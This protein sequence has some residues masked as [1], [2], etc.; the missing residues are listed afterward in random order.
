M[1]AHLRVLLLAVFSAFMSLNIW[2]QATSQIQGTVQDASGAAVPGATVK[3]TQTDT[4]FTRTVTSSAE[5]LY[6]LSNLPIGPYTLE[7]TKDGFSRYVQTGIVLQVNVS[8]T[9]DIPLR[10]GAVTEQVN[11]EANATLVETQ[12]TGVGSVIENQ[13]ILELPLNG[14]NATDLIQ[15]AGGA[16]PQGTSSSR[17]MQGGQAIAVAGGQ[18]Y[19]IAYF[20][21]GTT[22]NNPYDNLNLPFP[23]PDSLQE[24]KVETGATTAVNGGH[25]GA[26]VNAVT[27]SGTNSFH[28]SA[29]EFLRNAAVNGRDPFSAVRDTLKRNQYGG[30]LGGPIVRNKLFFFGGYQGTKTRQ[31]P[32]DQVNFIPTAQMLA[33]DF[34]AVASPACNG[35]RQVNLT[36][37]LF[38]GTGNNLFSGNKIDPANLS[39]AAKY[40]AARLPTTNDP[41]GRISTGPTTAVNESQYVGRSDYQ[42]S[43]KQTIFGRYMATTYFQPTPNSFAGS[44]LLTTIRGGRDNFA[45]SATFGDT[46][47]FSP[48]MVNSFR[49]AF[50]RTAIHRTNVDFFSLPDAGVKMFSY[51]PHY[52]IF[53]VTNAFGLGGGTENDARF[54][55]STYQLSDDVS[56]VKGSHQIAFGFTAWQW[57]SK[58]LANVRSP[59]S[60]TFDGSATGLPLAD[61]LTGLVNGPN[62]FI[63]SSPNTLDNRQNYFAFYAQDTWKFNSRLTFNYGLR[64]EPWLPQTI[65]NNAI[66]SFDFGRFNQGI[67]SKVFTKAPVGF[68]FPGDSGFIGQSGTERRWKN[69]APR[70]GLAWDPKGDGKTSIRASFGVSFNYVNGQFYINASNAP[71]WGSE[72]RIQRFRFDDPFGSS[73]TT[74]IFPITFDANAPFSLFGPFLSVQPDQRTE[75]VYAWNL[76]IQRQ[77]TP[78]WFISLNYIGNQTV[79][80]WLTTQGNPATL[81]AC[82]PIASCNTTANTNQRRVLF[83]QNP[84]E[85]QFIGYMDRIDDGGTQQYHGMMVTVQRRLARG[86]SING[87]YTWS[88]CIGDPVANVGGGT[89]NVAQGYLNWDYRR[90]DRGDCIYDRR[91][92]ANLTGVFETP[93]FNNTAARVLGSNWRISGIYRIASGA[94]LT[95]F[96]TVDVQRSA[97]S[98]QR[99]N[100]IRENVLVS[101]PGSA[102]PATAR[103]MSWLD[104]AAFQPVA[105]MP[106]GQLGNMSPFTVR[107]PSLWGLDMALSRVFRIIEGHS[108][109][110]RGEAF[111]LTNSIRPGNP[112]TNLSV[113]TFGQ[114]LNKAGGTPNAQG[115]F[116][117]GG[118]AGDARIMQFALKYV[119]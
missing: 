106:V 85:G 98:F 77:L 37:E 12:A 49:V 53:N 58:S 60:L 32:T 101:S 81:T 109:E 20:L 57:R 90:F 105:S 30:T 88:H 78:A 104:S 39:P 16:V 97:T 51:M 56:W 59:G 40:I 99:L 13:R 23:F 65:V 111:N 54:R 19:G 91:H 11:V 79:H 36:T 118:D 102:C 34:T 43:D 7:V 115:T 25:A 1:Q 8:P 28:G 114:I 76:S 45:Q 87:N 92:I 89:G 117:I 31:T 9:I 22:H 72:I 55:T 71:P 82:T 103:C 112:V 4:G 61:F 5:G 100:Q 113:G 6:I 18:T 10:V 119:F 107:G 21:D 33:G 116:T 66:Y 41:C 35:G 75:R 24:F 2:A 14:R 26:A 110:V 29:F 68:L 42:V 63:Q 64:W 17:S 47:L 67:R 44:N 38:T 86:L 27:R 96:T 62:A 84:A 48:T 94:P 69:M 15:I 108:L 95:P 3:A 50:N 74:N 80:L 70:V 52:S 93:R 46:Y 73:G 83:R